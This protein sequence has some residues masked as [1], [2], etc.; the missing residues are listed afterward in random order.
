M[1]P[2]FPLDPSLIYLNH[3]AVSPWP[4]RTA[5]AV[6]KFAQENIRLGAAHYP[7]WMVEETRLREQIRTLIHAPAISDI[8]LVKNTSEAL[9]FVAGG[10]DFKP[11][12]ELIVLK[13]DFPSNRI[14]WEILTK[15]RNIKLVEVEILGAEDPEGALLSALTPKTKMMAISSVHYAT[16]LRLDLKRLG[17]EL[18]AQGVLFLVDAIQSAG[19]LHLDVEAMHIDF[20]MADGHKWLIAP[21]GLGFFYVASHIREFLKPIEFGWHMV[22][23]PGDYHQTEWHIAKSARRYECGSPNMLGVHALSA[24]LGLLLEE[25]REKIEHEVLLRSRYLQERIQAE[26][27]L[28]LLS[29]TRPQRISGI[30]SFRHRSIENERLFNALKHQ[31]VICAQRGDGIRFSPH[32]YTELVQLD[33]AV[34]IVLRCNET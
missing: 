16:G 34:D 26:P 10:L 22:E 7:R 18:K 8:A 13:K 9:S 23:Q 3:A 17:A 21:E 11:D 12:D 1:H 27:E 25:G 33:R 20:A 15:T 5:E 6:Q 28:E 32:Y 30:V 24:S 29:D 4:K 14:P 31:N 2:E 19:A